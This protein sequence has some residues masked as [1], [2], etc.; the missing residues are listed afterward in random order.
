ML[1][2]K[3]RLY[4]GSLGPDPVAKPESEKLLYLV[5]N[6]FIKSSLASVRL[7][8]FCNHGSKLVRFQRNG[9]EKDQFDQI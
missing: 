6:I 8:N 2:K 5:I 9:F 3:E 1:T 7:W 4:R